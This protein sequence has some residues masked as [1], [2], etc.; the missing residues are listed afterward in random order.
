[1]IGR[2]SPFLVQTKLALVFFSEKCA[3]N[4]MA[5][6]CL[7]VLIL[8]IH[9]SSEIPGITSNSHSILLLCRICVK[10]LP[11]I[12]NIYILHKISDNAKDYLVAVQ[13]PS[14]SK[15]GRIGPP[16]NQ[17]VQSAL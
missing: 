17:R 12:Q 6:V 2:L 5:R 10:H 16:N 14:L 4:P 11:P 3:T 8:G 13:W 7:I 15:S 9:L 1:M